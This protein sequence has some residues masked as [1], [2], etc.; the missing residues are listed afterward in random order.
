MMPFVYGCMGYVLG[1]ASA[2]ALVVGAMAWRGLI[3]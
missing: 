3:H 1:V 2:L